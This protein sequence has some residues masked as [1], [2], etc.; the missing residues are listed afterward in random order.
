MNSE[1][2]WISLVWD[3]A[4]LSAF[5]SYSVSSIVLLNILKFLL[6]SLRHE[7]QKKTQQCS[8]GLLVM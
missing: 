5:Q 6:V 4:V 3:L 7:C 2:L 1:L 8:I